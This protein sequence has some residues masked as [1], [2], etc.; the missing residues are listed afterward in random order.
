MIPVPVD[1]EG[2][3]VEAGLRLAPDFRLAFVTPS[4]QHPTGV[5]MSLQRRADLLRAANERDAWIVEDDYDG[6]FRYDGRAAADAEKRRPCRARHLCRHLLARSMFPSLQAR[7]LSRAAGRWCR[8]SSASRAPS[9]RAC[10]RASRRC[11]PP[12][13]TEGHFATHL[14]AHARDLSRAPR[15]LPRRG[16]R[17]CSAACSTSA[18]AAGFHVVGRFVLAA[19][20]ARRTCRRRRTRPASSCRRSAASA[21][22]RSPD[23]GLV[24]GVSAIDPRVHP[25]GRGRRWPRCWKRQSRGLQ[26][27]VLAL[28][29]STIAAPF[30][31][32][33]SVGALVLPDVTFGKDRCVDHAQARRC[34]APAAGG[35]RRCRSGQAPCGRCRRRGRRCRRARGCRRP[36]R[37]PSRPSAPGCIS[38]SISVAH[39][40]LRAMRRISRTPASMSLQVLRRGE[41]VRLDHRRAPS[42]RASAMRIA[43]AA[44]RAAMRDADEEARKRIRAGSAGARRASACCS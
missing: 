40:R 22:S 44:L 37:P 24:L 28:S 9:C 16:R 29:S 33:I 5:E 20:S 8:S 11:S 43:A 18:F 26:R 25:Q 13:S 10:R 21:S 17:S 41:V 34:H 35:R 32:T 12:S 31:A 15:G 42:D 4:H 39:R 1:A 30:S 27:P 7:L 14:Q 38:S 3:S 6:E 23:K 36:A 19:S 2:L